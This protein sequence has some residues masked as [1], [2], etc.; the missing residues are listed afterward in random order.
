[1]KDKLYLK[2]LDFKIT[3]VEAVNEWI[4]CGHTMYTHIGARLYLVNRYV[5]KGDIRTRYVNICSVLGGDSFDFPLSSFIIATTYTETNVYVGVAEKHA[6]HVW[7]T[8]M[9]T[10]TAL[11]KYNKKIYLK[12]EG[13]AL[14][15]T[16]LFFMG[17]FWKVKVPPFWGIARVQ[18]MKD[19]TMI[20]I[21]T[22]DTCC[23]KEVPIG[24]ATHTYSNK[25][26][27]TELAEV[28]NNDEEIFFDLGELHL[29]A[30]TV[31]NNKE[32]S[33]VKITCASDKVLYFARE[34]VMK[35]VRVGA[36]VTVDVRYYESSI[37]TENYTVDPKY[38]CVEF[39]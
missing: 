39:I 11:E 37:G 12:E 13:N 20:D 29:K 2:R 35:I 27:L 38:F 6:S 30:D 32:M 18:S 21:S 36:V 1:M 15:S 16:H 10:L 17:I 4:M 22:T 9:E 31:H 33:M 34:V 5:D 24:E 8:K 19:G 28:V 25:Y 7:D 3:D 26:G 23:F 14:Y